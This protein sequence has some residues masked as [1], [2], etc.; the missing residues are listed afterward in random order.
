MAE[1]KEVRLDKDLVTKCP[2]AEG[3]I[4][5]ILWHREKIT[6]ENLE[7]SGFIDDDQSVP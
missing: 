5:L 2:R 3:M 6:K 7:K 4:G 1:L